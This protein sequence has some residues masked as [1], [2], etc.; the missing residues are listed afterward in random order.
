MASTVNLQYE[1][2]TK[3]I[4]LFDGRVHMPTV[5]DM[6]KLRVAKINGV[7]APADYHG[8]TYAKFKAGDTLD[9]SGPQTEI[10]ALPGKLQSWLSNTC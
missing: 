9:I 8:F 1:G 10:S 6:F 2:L 3:R 4:A 7:L 5:Q